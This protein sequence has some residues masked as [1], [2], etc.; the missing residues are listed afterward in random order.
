MNKRKN[1]EYYRSLGC[2]VA[3]YFTNPGFTNPDFAEFIG[4]CL[5]DGGL[6]NTQL[7]ITLN[8]VADSDYVKYVTTSILKLFNYCPSVSNKKDACAVTIR[9]TGVDFVKLLVNSGLK[10]GVKTPIYYTYH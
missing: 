1:P 7:G 6:T 3:N 9:V 5:G 4:I 10:I 2:I 8:R